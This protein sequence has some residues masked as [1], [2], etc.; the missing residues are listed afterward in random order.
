MGSFSMVMS[1][2]PQPNEFHICQKHAAKNNIRYHDIL[3]GQRVKLRHHSNNNSLPMASPGIGDSGDSSAVGA[4]IF[5]CSMAKGGMSDKLD[6]EVE[7]LVMPSSNIDMNFIF[8]P[9]F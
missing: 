8:R 3:I 2:P 4:F 5:M 9:Q 6:D 1:P 7:P